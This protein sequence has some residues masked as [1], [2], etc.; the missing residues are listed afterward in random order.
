MKVC[1]RPIVVRLGVAAG[2]SGA[3]ICGS[4]LRWKGRARQRTL[5]RCLL[6]GAQLRELRVVAHRSG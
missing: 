1:E 5:P 4:G 2:C 3:G 6:P